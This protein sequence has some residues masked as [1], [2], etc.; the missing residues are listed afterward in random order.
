MVIYYYSVL[1]N[2]CVLRV[3]LKIIS[4]LQIPQKS[5]CFCNSW[6][7]YT[8][9]WYS[10]TFKFIVSQQSKKK[11][12]DY[13]LIEKWLLDFYSW[14]ETLVLVIVCY[15]WLILI[16]AI[17]GL[18]FIGTGKIPNFAVPLITSKQNLHQL[19]THNS[20][21]MVMFVQRTFGHSRGFKI[22][23]KSQ[24]LQFLLLHLSLLV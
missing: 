6:L 2:T 17:L 21:T 18:Y 12:K 23:I 13:F 3:I 22:F 16:L 7:R 4:T 20:F 11:K 10:E 14:T 8:N 24:E 9:C 19:S 5:L 15:S 1:I